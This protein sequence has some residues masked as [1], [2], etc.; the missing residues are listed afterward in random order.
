[1]KRI[2]ILGSTGS[3]GR[4][5]IEIAEAHPDRFR[6]VSLATNSSIELVG[7]QSVQLRPEMVA[8][9]DEE[10]AER[11][12]PIMPAGVELLSGSGSLATLASAESCDVVVNGIVGYAGLDSTLAAL[13]A[14]KTLALANKE[15]MVVG[16]DLVLEALARG[17][18]SL[19]PV[20]SEHSAVFQCLAG[21]RRQDIRRIILTG[22]GGPFRG[23]DR[24]SLEEVTV[25]EALA[26][27]TWSMGPKI[28]IDSATMMNKGLEIIEAR[29]LFDVDYDR[30]E[31]LI[32]PQSIVHSMVEFVDGSV[33]AQLGLP[34]MRLPILYAMTYP[35][36]AESALARLDLATVR[37]LTFENP[38]Y[39]AFPAMSLAREAGKKGQTYPAVLNAANE[40]AVEN[41]LA[42]EIRFLDI[43][44]VIR[45]T[46]DEHTPAPVSSVEQLRAADAWARE[47]ARRLVS[48]A[49]GG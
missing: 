44:A 19:V 35:E 13:E 40:V 47:T 10:A 45:A 39:E 5:A 2:C 12:R 7:R 3:I 14:E 17:G 21:E 34:D 46:L 16:G 4:Q 6:V 38:N 43:V 36:R 32:H 20:D 8:V 31:V 27:P 37:E 22:S 49:P 26:H 9:A 1:M 18:G 41:F 29:Y 25:K 30:I 15:S 24:A 28:T 42:G 48:E 11:L 33:K 23:R